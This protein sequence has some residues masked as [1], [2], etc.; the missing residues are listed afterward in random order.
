[1]W[2]LL[3]FPC[4]SGMC[5]LELPIC[6]LP[7]PVKRFPPPPHRK[8]RRQSPGPREYKRPLVCLN[9]PTPQLVI[10]F[11]RGNAA[12]TPATSNERYRLT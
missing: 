7:N 5:T 4:V 12:H 1:M 2:H 3:T 11:F 9:L 6:D 10:S 8:N